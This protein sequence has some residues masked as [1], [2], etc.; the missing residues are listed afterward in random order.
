MPA[1][2]EAVAVGW[3]PPGVETGEIVPRGQQGKMRR[4]IRA[5][6]AVVLI[7]VVERVATAVPEL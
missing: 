2:A 6:V 4:R 1:V 7:M 5:G 3:R